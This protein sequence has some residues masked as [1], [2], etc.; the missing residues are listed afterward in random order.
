MYVHDIFQQHA[1]KGAGRFNTLDQ[2]A[3]VRFSEACP[4]PAMRRKVRKEQKVGN[5]HN[6][7]C[8]LK[9][10]VVAAP[11]SERVPGRVPMERSINTKCRYGTDCNVVSIC[12]KFNFDT[13]AV[14]HTRTLEAEACVCMCC[15]CSHVVH[16]VSHAA[17]ILAYLIH[18][19]TKY[20]KR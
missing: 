7:S 4:A 8:T 2:N 19:V 6:Y 11:A 17:Y 16:V 3:S 13:R 5:C 9:I 14:T 12:Q 1:A 20:R 18:L 10:K 15:C